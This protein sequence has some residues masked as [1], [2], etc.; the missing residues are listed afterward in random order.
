MSGENRVNAYLNAYLTGNRIDDETPGA[1]AG[2]G[3]SLG[4][5]PALATKRG[6]E[7]PATVAPVAPNDSQ[8]MGNHPGLVGDGSQGQAVVVGGKGV[9]GV[10]S[11][12]VS[13]A[14]SVSPTNP[15]KGLF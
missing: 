6:P 7:T 10:P 1:F 15:S 4:Y 5:G 3:K 8:A 12:A 14:G 11:K 13:S 2:Q 9:N